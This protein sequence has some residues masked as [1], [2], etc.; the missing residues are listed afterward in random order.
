MTKKKQLKPQNDNGHDWS[1]KLTFSD[2]VVI[3][4]CAI[5][6]LVRRSSGTSDPCKGPTWMRPFESF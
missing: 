1:K 4:C 2:G 3:T 6:G 5:C